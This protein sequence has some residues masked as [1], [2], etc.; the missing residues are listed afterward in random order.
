MIFFVSIKRAREICEEMIARNLDIKRFVECRADYFRPNFI[1]ESFLDLAVKSRLS[2][3]AIS[4]ESGS[5]RILN[6]LGKD[7]TI[8]QILTCAKKLSKYNIEANFSYMVG[9]P[10]ETKEDVTAT[11]E[12]AKKLRKYVQKVGMQ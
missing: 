2:K 6:L 9:I 1:D 5:Q 10:G 12:L 11:K 4:A 7:I 8:E 3:L